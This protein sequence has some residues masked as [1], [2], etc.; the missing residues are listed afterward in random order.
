MVAFIL[1]AQ[2]FSGIKQVPLYCTSTAIDPLIFARLA[3]VSILP[4]QRRAFLLDPGLETDHSRSSRIDRD[5]DRPV[6]RID[7]VP[8]DV[9]RRREWHLDGITHDA[10][11]LVLK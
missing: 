8:S 9:P 2:Q 3:F 1:A 4:L 10:R 7:D 6:E 5:R 11:T